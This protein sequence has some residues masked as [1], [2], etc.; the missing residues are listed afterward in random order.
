MA[1]SIKNAPKGADSSLVYV[2]ETGRFY[3]RVDIGDVS[4]LF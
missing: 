3:I 1:I 4:Y 2:K